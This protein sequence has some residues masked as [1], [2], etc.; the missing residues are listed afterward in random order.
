MKW[1]YAV[2]VGRIEG[3]IEAASDAEAMTAATQDALAKAEEGV[4]AGIWEVRQADDGANN[5]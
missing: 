3:E 4:L 5:G 2:D 1:R